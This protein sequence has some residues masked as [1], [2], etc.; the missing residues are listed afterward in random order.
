MASHWFDKALTQLI[1]SYMVSGATIK[2]ALCMTNT[3]ADTVFNAATVSALTLDEC[4]GVNYSR[5]TLTS[6]AANQDDTDTEGVFDADDVTFSSLGAGSRASQGALI[7]KFGTSDS[8]SVPLLWVEFTSPVT[9]DGT[10][11][12]IVWNSSGIAYV[13]N[14]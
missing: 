8:D 10:D 11:F 14:G 7:F 13:Q 4:D 12:S 1:N 5:K 9:H 6:L 3:T 2:V